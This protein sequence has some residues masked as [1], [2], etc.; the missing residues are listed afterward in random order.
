MSIYSNGDI[1]PMEI[2]QVM[3]IQNKPLFKKK[4][5]SPFYI[6]ITN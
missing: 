2:K 4:I 5:I 1:E 3:E 6:E